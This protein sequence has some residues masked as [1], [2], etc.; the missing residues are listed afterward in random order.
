MQRRAQLLEGADVNVDACRSHKQR[1]QG[2]VSE[3][4]HVM[5][6][7][8]PQGVAALHRGAVPEQSFD[9]CRVAGFGGCK[10]GHTQR[11]VRGR[12][13]GVQRRQ[14]AGYVDVAGGGG[15]D[16]LRTGAGT[17]TGTGA[18]TD[19]CADARTDVRT[20]ARFF[21]Q[22]QGH[23]QAAQGFCTV[24]RSHTLVPFVCQVTNG[25]QGQHLSETAASSG[26]DDWRVPTCVGGVD[27][28]IG[29]QQQVQA[30]RVVVCG[31]ARHT[32]VRFTRRDVDAQIACCGRNGRQ[33]RSRVQD[34]TQNRRAAV[35]AS[36]VSSRQPVRA[37]RGGVGVWAPQHVHNVVQGTAASSGHQR[38][39]GGDVAH[40]RRGFL[41]GGPEPAVPTPAAGDAVGAV[42]RKR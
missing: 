1:S 34:R 10:H 38:R 6:R 5:Q 3:I 2:S 20:D 27:G 7:S 11:C 16:C 36:D 23:I 30:R 29:L 41:G 33:L 37:T 31:G 15:V 42:K 39:V 12:P 24:Q 35:Q 4:R 26:E 19:A 9:L 32:E 40:R 28:G 14:C 21:F 22:N 18:R 13:A 8:P 17:G 25:R